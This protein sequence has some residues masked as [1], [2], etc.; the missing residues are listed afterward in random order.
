MPAASW[1]WISTLLRFAAPASTRLLNQLEHKIDVRHGDLF[2]PV[3]GERFDL[4]L[5]NPPFVAGA[6]Q[7][8]RDRAWRSNDV[9]ER[10][11]AGLGDHLKPGGSALVLLSTF[12]DGLAFLNEFRKQSF[13]ISVLAERRFVNERLTLFRLRASAGPPRNRGYRDRVATCSAHQSDNHGNP[14]RT[15]PSRGPEFVIVAR[16]QVSIDDH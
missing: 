16:R 13:A 3:A 1:R 4:I 6:P 11:A 10:F 2:A 14:S 9:A 12:G 8:D 5:F 7:G 15:R